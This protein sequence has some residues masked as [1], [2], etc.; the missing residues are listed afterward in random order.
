MRV[1]FLKV[2]AC[3]VRL[4]INMKPANLLG[5]SRKKLNLSSNL[6]ACSALETHEKISKSLD[7]ICY[8]ATHASG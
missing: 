4:D 2:S 5:G 7:C 3:A 1:M 6:G 8:R